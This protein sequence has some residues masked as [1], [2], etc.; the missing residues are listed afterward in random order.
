MRR[1]A[2][3]AGGRLPARV[4]TLA[5]GQPTARALEAAGLPV[6]G[7]AQDP[8][9]AGLARAARSVLGIG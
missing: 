5:I 8:G 3:L 1:F 2:Q 4:H 9:P 7:T 6:H